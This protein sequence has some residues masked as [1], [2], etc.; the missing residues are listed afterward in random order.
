MFQ[1]RFQAGVDRRAMAGL[2]CDTFMANRN[3]K[4][5]TQ[6]RRH[7][8]R[9]WVIAVLLAVVPVGPALFAVIPKPEHHEAR[10]EIDQLEEIWRTA[11]LKADVASLNA[12][13]ADDYMGITASG[14]LQ[15]KDDLLAGFRS[16]KVRFT[17]LDLSDRKIRFY[18]PTAL[19]T[20]RAEIKGTTTQ[21]AISGSY[22]YTRVY[23]RDPS[24]AWKI[25]S[26]E[27]SPIRSSGEHK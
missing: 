18:G 5:S 26:F 22:R 3:R 15:S 17:V 14:T 4:D 10:H 23:V 19:V 2:P 1:R 8:P 21:G 7:W 25:V 6:D 9:V 13:L 16:G 11:L 20:S 24:G 12:L 27:A